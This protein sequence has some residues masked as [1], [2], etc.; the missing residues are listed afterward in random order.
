[1]KKIRTDYYD[2]SLLAA[3]II[4]VG[5]GL[6]MLYS[7]SAYMAEIRLGDDMYYFRKQALIS[8]VSIGAAVAISMIDYHHLWK[9][10]GIIYITSI[11]LMAMVRFTPMGKKINGARRWLKLGPVQFQP[12]EIAK[13]AIVV[14]IPIMIVKMGRMYR[15]WKAAIPPLFMGLVSAAATYFFTQNLSTAVIIFMMCCAIVFVAHPKTWGFLAALVL[16]IG[17]VALLVFLIAKN[18]GSSDAFRVMRVL[19]WLDPEKYSDKGGYQVLQGLYAIGSGGLFGKGLGNSAQ[20]L[21][22][23]PE[24]QNDMI[25]SIVCEELGA[26]VSLSAVQALLYRA[27]RAGS[28]WR[29]HGDRHLRPYRLP[30]GP[31]YRGGAEP[32]PH[33]RDHASVLQLRGHL[34]ASAADG[35]LHRPLGVPEDL[36]PAGRARSLGRRDRGVGRLSRF[37]TFPVKNAG[38]QACKPHGNQIQSHCTITDEKGRR[39]SPCLRK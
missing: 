31:Q 5:F 7:T 4:L 18:A 22:P 11:V 24:A 6:V 23:V 33:D 1:M 3:I 13:I 12:S 19:V 21:G 26:A 32:D 25:F 9:L 20:K 28:L 16:G 15:G 29:A 36:F 2:Y 27:E 38:K 8:I 39:P 35:D 17:A 10:G 14:F 37:W 30:G 34:G